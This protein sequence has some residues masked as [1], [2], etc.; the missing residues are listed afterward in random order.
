MSEGKTHTTASL[1]LATGFSVVAFA[2]NQPQ[3][4]ECAVGS[5]VGIF[6]SPD[7]DV[8]SGNVSGEIIRKRV[9]WFGERLWRWFWKDYSTSFKHGRFGSHFPIYGTATRLF[10]IFFKTVLPLTLVIKLLFF[11]HIDFI[12]ELT[13]WDTMVVFRPMVFIGLCGSDFIHAILDIAT[14]KH[15]EQT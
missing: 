4:F 6:I 7:L 15:K 1:L 3:L 2:T 10:Y 14:T 8:D 11:S 12:C 9:G 5:L 13:W